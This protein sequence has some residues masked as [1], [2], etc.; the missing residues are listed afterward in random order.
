MHAGGDNSA[1]VKNSG[2]IYVWGNNP[3]HGSL[4]TGDQNPVAV[5]TSLGVNLS[6]NMGGQATP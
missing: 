4:S 2:D 3:P 5:P 6:I 1:A